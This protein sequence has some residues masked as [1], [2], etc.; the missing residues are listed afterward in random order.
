MELSENF[1]DMTIIERRLN[2]EARNA[3]TQRFGLPIENKLKHIQNFNMTREE[4]SHSREKAWLVNFEFI[5]KENKVYRTELKLDSNYPF[6]SPYNIMINGR[7]YDG[8]IEMGENVNIF[9]RQV[10]KKECLHCN[11][12]INTRNW[13]PT[14]GLIKI[15]NEYIESL[16]IVNNYENFKIIICEGIFDKIPQEIWT[17][18]LCF[19]IFNDNNE[20]EIA[21][22]I[23]K[24]LN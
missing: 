23:F 24:Y 14:F 5:S 11:S 19:L 8:N 6:R 10:L 7:Y 22:H 15:V 17:N 16:D 3:N 9:F 13:R 21:N 2:N 20:N 1:N 12:C 4:F 18:V